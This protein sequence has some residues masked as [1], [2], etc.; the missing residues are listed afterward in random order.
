MAGVSTYTVSRALGGFSDVSELTAERIQKIA[1]QIGYTPNASARFLSTKKTNIIGMIVPTIGSETAYNEVLNAVSK[2]AADNGLC[3]QL[4]SCD[5]NIELEKAYCRM[6][7]ENRVEAL[8]VVP[9]SSDISHIK[10]ICEGIVPLI[11]MG[12]KTGQDITYSIA[13][14]Y[15]HSARQAVAHLFDLGHREI[16]IFLYHPENKTIAMKRSGYLASMQERGLEP[17]VY[18]EGESN[19]TFSAGFSLTEKLL[20][21]N[22]LPSAIWCASDLMAFGVLEALK[23]HSL[24]VP[25]DV[26]VMGHDNLFFTST[27]SIS[28]TTF[29][30]PNDQMG[31]HAVN[32]ALSIMGRLDETI[33]KN[34]TF[35]S[36]FVIR[37]ST[38]NPLHSR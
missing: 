1:R 37:G 32:L 31:L 20:A 25:T 34:L 35:T 23:K 2:A 22:K 12:G 6:M 19:D 21:D 24:K 7:C 9:M 10:A 11:F 8:I 4:G 17:A 28:L 26:S 15:T 30:L 5:R 13:I 27:P 18:M 33:E 3:V 38:S 36:S 16:A 29:A 14:D